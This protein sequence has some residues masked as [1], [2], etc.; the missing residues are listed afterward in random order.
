M[1]DEEGIQR[2]GCPYESTC[3]SHSRADRAAEIP[4]RLA[5][6]VQP[7]LLVAALAAAGGRLL[8]LTPEVGNAETGSCGW[9]HGPAWEKGLGAGRNQR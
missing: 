4:R 9:P 1:N 2:S 3:S 6:S 7:L 8:L 5:R